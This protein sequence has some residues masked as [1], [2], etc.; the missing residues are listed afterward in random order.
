MSGNDIVLID[1]SS[2]AYPIYMMSQAEPDPNHT[3]QQ[4][5]ARVRALASQQPYVAICCDGGRSFR[6]D[7]AESYKAN[8]PAAEAPLHHQIALAC[9]QLD[10]DGF[11]V[12]R[13]SGFEADDVI[14]TAVTKALALDPAVSVR[15]VTGDKDLLQLVSPRVRAMSVRDGS[16]LDEHGVWVK[17][18]VKPEQM[19]D[20][21][22]LV[23]D[24][25]DNIK[26]AQGI[27]PKKA[28]ELLQAYGS[29][30]AVYEAL[31]KH[32]ITFKP[33]MATALQEFKAR[34]AETR[35]LVTL[36]TDVEIP[37][38]TIAAE[39]TP[40]QVQPCEPM[41]DDMELE[42]VAEEPQVPLPVDEP[43]AAPKPEPAP[44]PPVAAQTALAVVKEAEVVANVPYERQLDPRSLKDAQ[45]LA[46]NMHASRLFSAY[47]TPQAVLST[48]I[49]GR[50]LGLPAMGS[51]RG[52]HI[53]EGKHA[54]SA[55][56]MVALVLRSG[57]AEY[58]EPIEFD[59]TKATFE[60]KRVGAR[61]PVKLTHTIE[62]AQ[63][64]GLVKPNSNWVKLPEEMLI[65]R[66]KAR[67]C[68]LV[69]PDLLGG[70]YTPDELRDSSFSSG[71]KVA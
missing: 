40:K 29:L 61:K 36:R 23:G 42:V 16:I 31:Q 45:V 14:A 58:F 49:L 62:Q 65:A 69:Y 71:E 52:V 41:E 7:I 15:I 17:F 53:I 2:I 25:S 46:T 26:G 13:V 8:R 57:L 9:E 55:D 51:L 24:S 38:E 39:R 37:F 47:G 4:I 64:A 60:T 5:V 20:Y 6:K 63:V 27:G 35:A 48:I 32:P 22:T 50:E 43:A 54:L 10:A 19:R 56:T 21:L 12:W 66:A 1:L 44:A 18:A 11:P 33:A 3:A 59:A 67:L 28:A 30:D 68:R 34:L 70:L